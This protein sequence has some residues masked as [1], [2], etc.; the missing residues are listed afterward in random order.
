MLP[1]RQ[2]PPRSV[3]SLKIRG[4]VKKLKAM[5]A[6]DRVQLMVKAKLMSQEEADEAKRKLA[7][8]NP[9]NRS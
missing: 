7:D 8:A 6:A 1:K 4:A 3:T 5:P 9:A 2:K